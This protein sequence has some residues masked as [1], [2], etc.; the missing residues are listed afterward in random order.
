MN[1]RCLAIDGGTTNTR[2][3]LLQGQRAVATARRKVG[4][5]DVA[6][7]G[8]ASPVAEAV[9]KCIAEVLEETGTSLDDVEFIAA[10]G[11]L[12][13]NV[14]LIDLPHLPAPV[15]LADLASAVEIR[16]LPEICDKAI[17]FVRGVRLN[18]DDQ[19]GLTPG[20]MMRG[21][22][23]ET[24]G[25]LQ[26]LDRR[27]R[28]QLILPGSHTKLIQID[29]QG[30]IVSLR[31]SMTGEMLDALARHTVLAASIPDPLPPELDEIFLEQ[32]ARWGKEQGLLHAAFGVRLAQ[33][34]QGRSP[35][36]CAAL[37]VGAV[38]GTDIL[39]MQRSGALDVS[40]AVLVAG[41]ASLRVVYARLL[42]TMLANTHLKVQPVDE[43]HCQVAAAVGAASIVR[44]RLK[45]NTAKEL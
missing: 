15:S 7:Q 33:V 20:D 4:A 24:F 22:E 6:R 36:Q 32:G 39:E 11:M 1:E 41:S 40:T 5:R 23:A 37:L 31:T 2:A 38:I 43:T 26:L 44:Q 21:E 35:E 18:R 30:R 17:H 9:S 45:Q 27:D 12:T 42:Q 16:T 10:S 19:P 28:T 25:L 13:S 29:D 8:Q 3:V 14:G 34:L